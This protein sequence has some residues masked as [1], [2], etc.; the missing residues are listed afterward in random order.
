MNPKELEILAAIERDHWFYS[1]KRV[2]VRRWLE[3]LGVVGSARLMVD[4]GAGTGQF[5]AELAA[6]GS[7][8]VLAVDESFAAV[9]LVR[10]FAQV[11]ATVSCADHLALADGVADVVT[12]LDVV[13]HLQEDALAV[14]EF[15]R[16][17]RPGGVVVL[18]APAFPA[19]WSRWDVALGHRRRYRRSQLVHLLR[20]AGALPIRVAYINTLAFPAVWL[21]RRLQDLG[22]P[23]RVGWRAE[24]RVPPGWI[25][26]L[27]RWVFVKWAL[28][29]LPAPF[30]VSV[31]AM[32]RKPWGAQG[33]QF[34]AGPTG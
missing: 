8:K 27:L 31:L 17:L 28:S 23:R 26:R 3:R 29:P 1:G 20:Q 22:T 4:V 16:V 11:A 7:A 5:A 6:G 25:N 33:A 30:G 10:R 13:E 2:L 32:G 34:L 15:L 9:R 24:D 14:R 19:L 12:A 21:L 18:T